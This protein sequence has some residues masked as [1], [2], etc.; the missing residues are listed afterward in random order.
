MEGLKLTDQEQRV[1]GELF[2]LCDVEATGKV[3]GLKA[4]ELFLSS[5]LSQETL[6]Q[7]PSIN[8][9]GL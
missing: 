4:S 5:G 3:T 9:E 6:H 2:G 8:T 7:V 1:Y